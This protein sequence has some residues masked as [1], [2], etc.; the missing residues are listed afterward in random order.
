MA[1]IAFV[2][3]SVL[4][5]GISMVAMFTQESDPTFGGEGS[6]QP[7]WEDSQLSARQSA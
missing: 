7:S 1:F 5:L 6:Y 3:W 4:I 2:I